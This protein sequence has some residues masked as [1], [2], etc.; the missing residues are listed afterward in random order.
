MPEEKRMPAFIFRISYDIIAE[1]TPTREALN[2][3]LE[4]AG[5]QRYKDSPP[6]LDNSPSITQREYEK[7]IGVVWQVFDDVQARGIFRRTGVRG[8]EILTRSG[9]LAFT[10]FLRAFDGLGTKRERAAM[11]LSRLTDELSRAMG[12]RHVF[13]REGE[14]FIM[15]IHECPY[16]AELLHRPGVL[17]DAH[18]CH[19]PMAFYEAAINWASGDPHTVQ[20]I[21]C[22]VTTPNQD[23]CR[24]RIYWNVGL[25]R[26]V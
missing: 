17:P 20:E 4:L 11:A 24:F 13:R 22:R 10:Q 23:F 12:Y 5:L 1:E 2:R 26:K 14:D 25:K 18:F 19:A 3:V 15:D 8:F 21:A 6:P 7:M 16:C 9:A